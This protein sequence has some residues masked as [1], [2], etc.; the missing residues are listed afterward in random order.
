MDQTVLRKNILE[1]Y[2]SSRLMPPYFIA[3]CKTLDA[4]IA[5]AKDV[6][7][8]LVNEGLLVKVKEELYFDYLARS[9]RISPTRKVTFWASKYSIN[10]MTYLRDAPV[11]SLN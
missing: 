6:L 2:R 5:Q 11:I 1:Q 3:L 8:L 9:L 10:G 7:L 4:E